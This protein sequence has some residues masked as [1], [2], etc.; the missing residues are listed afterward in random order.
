LITS[1]D[2][3]SVV[4]TGMISSIRYIQ[5][6]HGSRPFRLPGTLLRFFQSTFGIYFTSTAFDGQVAVAFKL[7]IKDKQ[8]FIMSTTITAASAVSIYQESRSRVLLFPATVPE[9]FTLR[10]LAW[11]EQ[12]NL[13]HNNIHSDRSI[14]QWKYRRNSPQGNLYILNTYMLVPSLSCTI[15]QQ[16]TQ[17]LA[18]PHNKQMVYCN[19]TSSSSQKSCRV[20]I[21]FVN[22]RT[23]E[24]DCSFDLTPTS[25]KK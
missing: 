2:D 4:N 11:P 18:K 20:Q 21:S 24:P 10:D 9:A 25:D 7:D 1:T 3:Q 14:N 22:D 5:W 15:D 17:S 19:N 6:L 23:D 16:A 12:I 8:L 13:H